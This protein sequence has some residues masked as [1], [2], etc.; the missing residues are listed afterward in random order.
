MS[1]FRRL[2]LSLLL[3]AS[4]GLITPATA[5]P[6]KLFFD[7]SFEGLGTSAQQPLT[8][9]VAEIG[10]LDAGTTQAEIA[11]FFDASNFA[12]IRDR[13]NTVVTVTDL[14]SFGPGLPFQEFT[15]VADGDAA[16]LAAYKNP[17]SGPAGKRIV[18]WLRNAVN[19]SA[20]SEQAFLFSPNNFP[21][22]N[23]TLGF[24]DFSETVS[25]SSDAISQSNLAAGQI[26]PVQQGGGIDSNDGSPAD[27]KGLYGGTMV[28]LTEAFSTNATVAFSSGT[29]TI[30]ENAGS[31]TVTVVRTGKMDGEVT[32]QYTTADGTAVSGVDYQ[33]TAGTLTFAPNETSK[34]ITVPVVDR[35]GFQGTRTFLVN[36]SNAVGGD[37]GSP[38]SIMVDITDDEAPMS[39]QIVL[40]AATY[41]VNENGGSVAVSVRRV[42]GTDGA[43]SATIS[44]ANGSATA[45]QDY[46]AI[47]GQTVTF[48]AGDAVDKPVTITILND[49]TFEGDENFTVALSNPQGGATLGTP[50]SATV[51][52]VEDDVVPNAGSLSFSAATYSAGEGAATVL[53]TV[54]R[55]GGNTGAVTVTYNTSD[56]TANTAADYAATSGTLAWA[57]GDIADKTFTVSINN[58]TANEPDETFGLTLSNPTG[59][60]VLAS[61]ASAT[62]TIVDDEVD[63]AGAFAF[64]AAIYEVQENAGNATIT[65]IRT[66]GSDVAASVTYSASAGTATPNDDFTPATGTLNFAPGETEKT[67]TVAINNDTSFE[68]NET[69]NLALSNPTNGA[70]LGSPDTA[71]LTI[72]SDDGATTFSLSAKNYSAEE[73]ATVSVKVLR[74]GGNQDGTA[75]VRYRTID[76]TAKSPKDYAGTSGTLTFGP[77]ETEKTVE[78]ATVADAKDENAETFRFQLSVPP[79]AESST[80]LG[81]PHRAIVTIARNGAIDQP[82]LQAAVEDFGRFTGDDVYNTSGNG[83]IA[84]QTVSSGGTAKFVIRIE[85]DGNLS[86]SFFLKAANSGTANGATVLY[87][88]NGVDVSEKITT[89]NGLKIPALASHSETE[90]QIEVRFRGG[91]S[92]TGYGATITATSQGTPTATDVARVLGVIR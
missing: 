82:D 46:T 88:R 38:A 87:K 1:L 77:G 61:P 17:A 49:A 25:T 52:I 89:G 81:K 76:I 74:S 58:D 59:G 47:A 50:N 68:Q 20:A 23:D 90:I 37:L 16:G 48:A 24:T 8:Q 72:L 73:G 22:A 84:A 44:T 92:S 5:A 2:T 40:S 13:F 21:T 39:G 60:A 75:S 80:T 64:S 71:T 31:V 53:I 32:V 41:S 36:L 10:F 34:P 66:G 27:G 15:L 42:G 63:L 86:D 55:T 33:A 85:N 6:V 79:G 43:V 56:G 11:A 69:V 35:P 18:V 45:G 7:A 14:N 19:E 4:G 78:I 29:A 91:R 28:L 12:A 26:A 9:G 3:L 30:A 65:V 51:T 70:T 62:V 54:R 83:Q 57:D 67:F